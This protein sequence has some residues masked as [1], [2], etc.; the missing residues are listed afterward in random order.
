MVRTN[1]K[2]QQL[3]FLPGLLGH[4][5]KKHF[6]LCSLSF[7]FLISLLSNEELIFRRSLIYEHALSHI[8]ALEKRMTNSKD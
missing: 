7:I 2:N 8:P 6:A 4:G 3:P 5:M 1:N